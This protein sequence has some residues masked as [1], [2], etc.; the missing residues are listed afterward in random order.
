[1]L[2]KATT[3]TSLAAPAKMQ[4]SIV[5]GCPAGCAASLLLSLIYPCRLMGLRTSKEARTV[6]NLH[7]HTIS[8]PGL[9]NILPS[10]FAPSNHAP[11]RVRTTAAQ[12]GSD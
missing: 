11:A 9:Y 8:E 5:P 6:D 10:K 4:L 3:T 2:L 7:D 1:V 12:K